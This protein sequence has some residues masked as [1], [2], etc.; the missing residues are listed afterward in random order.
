[1]GWNHRECTISWRLHALSSEGCGSIWVATLATVSLPIGTCRTFNPMAI[2]QSDSSK[3][4]NNDEKTERTSKF[5]TAK[6]LIPKPTHES[7]CHGMVVAPKL[8]FDCPSSLPQAVG[9]LS[10]DCFS[11]IVSEWSTTRATN[12]HVWT[13]CKSNEG[14]FQVFV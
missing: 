9:I 7:R 1:M 12:T 10:M 14:V 6:L 5:H 13:I 4:D 11:G 2:G 3:V 8:R